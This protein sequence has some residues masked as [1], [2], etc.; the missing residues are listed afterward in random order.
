MSETQYNLIQ[1]CLASG[2]AGFMQPVLFNPL[3]VLRLRYQTAGD[4]AGS[5]VS[6]SSTSLS[7]FARHITITEGVLRG[8]YLPGLPAN[9][10]AVSL[11][12]G[13]RMGVYPD[14]RD[15]ITDLLCA[16]PQEEGAT[17]TTTTTIATTM[18]RN[19][20]VKNHDNCQ[21][22]RENQKG[23]VSMAIAGLLSG[24]FGYW[25]CAPLWL[26]KT[27]WQVAAQVKAE[28]GR[29]LEALQLPQTAIGFWRG[30]G[31]IV[32]RGACITSGQMLGYDG[33]KT[34]ALLSS[35]SSSATPP[36]NAW[37]TEDGPILHIFAATV[38]GFAAATTS[39][40]A[41]VLMTHYQSAPPGRYKSVMHCAQAL[42]RTAGI[43][44]FFRGWTANFLRLAPT[45]IF[46][47][48]IYEQARRALGLPYL[49]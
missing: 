15:A 22:R 25:M 44:S 42:W 27:R 14:V 23:P 30:A 29:Y 43:S 10:V 7:A 45:F 49:K 31:V 9:M 28:G 18:Q 36:E 13:L 6:S 37:L 1:N 33:T 5:H 12:Q 17:T 20:A 2:L 35:N 8:L 16:S 46:G 39:A 40:P 21:S 48:T 26:V 3:D 11:T 19:K 34:L 41:D 47:I 32:L 4:V 24:A 38:A